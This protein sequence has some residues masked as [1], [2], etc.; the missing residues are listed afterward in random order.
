MHTDLNTNEG[1]ASKRRTRNIELARISDA[2]VDSLVSN[3]ACEENRCTKFVASASSLRALSKCRVMLDLSA[4]DVG[5]I[6]FNLLG[7]R[8]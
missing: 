7:L 1:L 4:L 5:K 3:P 2:N 6:E 8:E